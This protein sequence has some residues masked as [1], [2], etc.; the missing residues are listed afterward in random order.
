MRKIVLQMTM[1]L[2]GFLAGPNNELDWM[3]RTPDDGEMN[4]D[5]VSI[6]ED[7]DTGVVG[8]PKAS[9]CR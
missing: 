4:K 2:D 8:Y 6:I 9:L 3:Q 5:I 1:S 7:A